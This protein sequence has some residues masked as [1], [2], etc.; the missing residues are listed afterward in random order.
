MG[1][2]VTRLR[3]RPSRVGIPM[4]LRDFSLLQKYRLAL[5]P[6]DPPMQW[7]PGYFLGI[8]VAGV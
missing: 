6:I 5:G 7:V 8:K 4:G 2:I 3:A 1:G